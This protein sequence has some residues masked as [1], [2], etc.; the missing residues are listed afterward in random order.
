MGKGGE[1]K[2][3]STQWIHIILRVVQSDKQEQDSS[4]MGPNC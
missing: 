4:V 1:N 2:T 3:N